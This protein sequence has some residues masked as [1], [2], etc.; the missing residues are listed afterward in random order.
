MHAASLA[1]PETNLH[2]ER[3]FA[4]VFSLISLSLASADY[5]DFCDRFSDSIKILDFISIQFCH[6]FL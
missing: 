1:E 2:I 4:S 6:L 5:W 3:Y